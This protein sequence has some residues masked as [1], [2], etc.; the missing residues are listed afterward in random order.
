MNDK[1]KILNQL[2]EIVLELCQ[3]YGK[4][5]QIQIDCNKD[6]KSVK[7]KITESFN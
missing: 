5:I 1:E 7:F 3:Q 2:R 6:M 4:N